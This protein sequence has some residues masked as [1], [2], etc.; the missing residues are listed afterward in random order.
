MSKSLT[1]VER[2]AADRERQKEHHHWDAEHDSEHSDNS[3]AIV[4]A[5]YPAPFPI[6][7]L[8]QVDESQRIFRDPWPLH[9]DREYDKRGDHSRIRQ[10]EKAGALI[11]AELDRITSEGSSA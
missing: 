4:A 3:L 8:L 11:A 7:K 6:F 9:W 1:G 2:I 5:L 10:L